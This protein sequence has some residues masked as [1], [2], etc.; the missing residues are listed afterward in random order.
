MVMGVRKFC[1]DSFL[2]SLKNHQQSVMDYFELYYAYLA[3]CERDNW[4]NYRDPNHD[5][6]E[7]NHTLPQCI[8]GDLPIG[9][10]LTIEQ[11]AVASALQTLAF[12]TNCLCG[13][14]RKYL[15]TFIWEYCLPLVR[16]ANKKASVLA[17]SEKTSKGKSVAAVTAAQAAA[18][19]MTADQ[20]KERSQKAGLAASA[21]MS[22]I[23]KTERARKGG[24]AA[25]ANRT[26]KPP[27][28]DPIGRSKLF[29]CTITGH[30]ST[31]GALARYQNNRG[32]PTTNRQELK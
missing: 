26:P 13:W 9:Q 22:T 2:C 27:K 31:A 32:I 29:Q 4:A 21:K 16:V 10:W 20:R 18:E 30:I 23:R 25:A 14:H 5:F 1:G 19:K 3:W 28:P 8:F 7:W 17:H 12:K 15:P 11:H 6:M 24:L